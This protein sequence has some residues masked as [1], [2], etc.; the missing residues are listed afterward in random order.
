MA[1]A[2]PDDAA[3][4]AATAGDQPTRVLLVLI[5]AGQTVL[6]DVVTLLLDVGAPGTIVE[7]RGL[8]SLL[9]EEMPIFSGLAS[10]LPE[11]SGSRVV[12]SATSSRVAAEVLRELESEFD[13]GT[14]PV[15]FTLPI[16]QSLGVAD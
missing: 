3:S 9:R 6:D 12:L 15:A 4:P 16:L 5:L 13:P 11:T 14:R 10:M 1:D 2:L 7:S 8:M